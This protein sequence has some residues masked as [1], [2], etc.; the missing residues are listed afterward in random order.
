MNAEWKMS[1]L[2][3]NWVAIRKQSLISPLGIIF[4]LFVARNSKIFLK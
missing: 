2:S 3:L 4:V 1:E